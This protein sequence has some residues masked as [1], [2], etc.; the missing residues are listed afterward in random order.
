MTQ[1]DRPA[2]GSH[3]RS[4]PSGSL[5]TS[6]ANLFDAMLAARE[7]E[8]RGDDRR[9][10]R[11]VLPDPDERH[12]APSGAAGARRA[13]EGRARLCRQRRRAGR[14]QRDAGQGGGGATRS[15]WASGQSAR[16]RPGRRQ[17]PAICRCRH[18]LRSRTWPR[19]S[20]PAIMDPAGPVPYRFDPDELAALADGRI[21]G[22]NQPL[23][24]P[25]RRSSI[26]V[27]VP[28]GRYA[29]PRDEARPR[30]RR[31]RTSNT[32]TSSRPRPMTGARASCSGW[33][34]SSGPRPPWT[35]LTEPTWCGWRSRCSPRFAPWPIRSTGVRADDERPRGHPRRRIRSGHARAAGGAQRVQRRA[36]RGAADDVQPA[37]R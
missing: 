8:E 10:A 15:A 23:F 12:A 1:T 19:P 33:S 32:P 16:W 7:A 5:E 26:R 20:L 35:S 34:A 18:A 21:P 37:R 36:H 28:P 13:G 22:S 30:A 3:D 9:H 27:R 31:L 25:T 6:A 24:E 17:T 29:R 14:D 11:C 2:P 4:S